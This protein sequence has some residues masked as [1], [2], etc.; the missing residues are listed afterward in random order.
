MSLVPRDNC[1][2]LASN[3]E[4]QAG[5]PGRLQVVPKP[6]PRPNFEEVA[7]ALQLSCCNYVLPLAVFKM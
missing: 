5:K 6:K 2:L 1:P 3:I 7:Q 4:L